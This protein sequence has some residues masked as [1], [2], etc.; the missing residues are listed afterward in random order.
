[1]KMPNFLIIG[2][3]KSGTTSLYSYLRQHPEVYMSPIKEPRFFAF[4]NDK[5]AFN[6][7]HDKRLKSEIITNI[8][9][10]RALFKAVNYEKAI[11][12][13]SPVYL[14]STKA[15]HRIKHYIPG[16]K[17]IAVL[18]NPTERAYSS[19]LAEVRDGREPLDDFSKA[20]EDEDR[21]IRNKWSYVWHYTKRGFYHAQLKR[22]FNMFD[23]DQ[24][25]VYLYEEWKADNSSILRNIFRFLHV[26]E[27]FKP[28]IS[29]NYNASLIPR[30]KFIYKI[31]E[32]AS[33]PTSVL[34]KILPS[35]LCHK[36]IDTIMRKNL[37]KPELS[38]D[39]RKN[40]IHVYR[41]DILKLQDLIERDL[42]AWLEP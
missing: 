23:R 4:E 18:R 39:I 12:E 29:I 6:G 27:T 31:I 2:A 19:F 33:R 20:I 36:T 28:D 3:S 25:K 38:S 32:N 11:G 17:L 42:S 14:Y 34:K 22:Y 40:L 16:A 8:E 10:Y 24:I 21:R 15:P 9:D 13:V 7:P 41:E 1:M 5:L 30:V 37:V 35:R 26:D